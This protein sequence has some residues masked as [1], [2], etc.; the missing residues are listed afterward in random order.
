M[1]EYRPPL[2]RELLL[3]DVAEMYY[4]EGKRQSEIARLIGLTTSMVSRL[5]TE[6]QQ[7]N[8]VEI[9]IRR[10]LQSDYALENA[11]KEKFNLQTVCVVTVRNHEFTFLKYLG[12]AGAQTFKR[13]LTPNSI[14][15]VAW[16]TTL[17]VLADELEVAVPV[18]SKLV[19]LVGAM[20]SRNSEYE[21][22][23]IIMRLAEKL[24]SEHYILNSPFLCSNAESARALLNNDIL[25]KPLDMARN[26]QI[27]LLGAGSL[28]LPYAT[29]YRY[30]YFSPEMMEELN[31]AGAVGNVC[32]LYYDINGQDVSAEFCNRLI[33]LNKKDLLSIPIR[34]GVVGGRDKVKPTLGA[35]RGGYFNVLVTDSLTAK[36]VLELA[37]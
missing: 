11:L 30:G 13:F 16:G 1:P 15:G 7:R 3:A 23:G 27:A 36:M 28:E 8:M 14:I 35:L 32:G 10:P 2:D 31:R 6:A 17:S 9:H 37:G 18:P 19:E 12:G 4:L 20:G 22:H 21:G 26:A 34:M 33:T 29:I 25:S 24:G 5:L